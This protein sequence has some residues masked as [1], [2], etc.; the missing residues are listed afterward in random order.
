WPYVHKIEVLYPGIQ[1]NES[2]GEQAA[3]IIDALNYP[4]RVMLI[5]NGSGKAANECRNLLGA[6][7]QLGNVSII[8]HDRRLSL[9]EAFEFGAS[10]SS[11]DYIFLLTEKLN[12]KAA[13]NRLIGCLNYLNGS[14]K[15]ALKWDSD[16]KSGFDLLAERS[17][18]C[19]NGFSKS[20]NRAEVV[21]PDFSLLDDFQFDLAYLE[22]NTKFNQGNYAGAY[23]A[24]KSALA[25][26]TGGGTPQGYS[27]FL[28][29][30]RLKLGKYAEA[31][32]ETRSLIKR[33]YE[34][35]NLIILGQILQVQKKF[36]EAVR[37]YHQGL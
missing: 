1:W 16:G 24:M 22:A 15:Y 37:A 19:A 2:A 21:R 33:G 29:N 9:P 12:L 23:T 20:F 7:S 10:K 26:K 13:S 3:E 32:K 35:D 17:L 25:L 30:I 18:F 11:A 31:E 4:V 5:N 28:F 34:P 27:S 6:A 14:D 8:S 36:E